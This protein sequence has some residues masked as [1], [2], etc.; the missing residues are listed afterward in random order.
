MDSTKIISSA[1]MM[2]QFGNS[3]KVAKENSASLNFSSVGGEGVGDGVTGGYGVSERKNIFSVWKKV[4]LKIHSNREEDENN[5]KRIPLGERLAGNTRVVDLKNGTLLV[6][7]DHPGWIQYLNMYKKF[8]IRG[9]NMYLPELNV[10]NLAFRT[11]GSSF[12]LH[13]NYENSVKKAQEEMIAKIEEQEKEI[14]KMFPHK[15]GE[16]FGQ[17]NEAN[18]NSNESL[19]E[20][21]KGIKKNPL[22]PELLLKFESIRQT[23]LT[24]SENK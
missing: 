10:R 15:N 13:E 16:N 6:E 17:E 4:V 1:D 3:F 22:P 8:I 21:L 23:V 14:E 5:E 7:T 12:T 18:E 24:N 19:G 9:I 11:A 20:K 2:K